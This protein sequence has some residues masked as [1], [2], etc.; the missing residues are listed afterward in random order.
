MLD[1]VINSDWALTNNAMSLGL[2]L[3]DEPCYVVSADIFFSAELI[4][5][6]DVGP[7]NLVLTDNRANRIQSAIHC[8]VDANERVEETYQGPVRNP[9]HPEAIGLF[10]ISDKTAIREWRKRCIMK[11]NM[12]VGQILPCE[13]TRIVAFP[14]DKEK[15]FEINTPAD[16]LH[17]IHESNKLS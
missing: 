16:Y 17:L 15:F 8:V 7:E 12:F 13:C 10:K 6:L 9:Q 4:H 14:L 11:G 1:F 3:T 2:A 5:K